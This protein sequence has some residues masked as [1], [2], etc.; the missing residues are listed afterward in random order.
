MRIEGEAPSTRWLGL[1]AVVGSLVCGVVLGSAGAVR[2]GPTRRPRCA[3]G[4]RPGRGGPL[5]GG[6]RVHDFGETWTGCCL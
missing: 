1:P 2:L 4:P 3:D 6:D 5:A